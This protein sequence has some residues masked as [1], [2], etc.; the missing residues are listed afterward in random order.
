M[1]Y[2]NIPTDVRSTVDVRNAPAIQSVTLFAGSAAA[3]KAAVDAWKADIANKYKA[4][5]DIF[6][7]N[8]IYVRQR[9]Q[10]VSR[11]NLVKIIDD[12][13]GLDQLITNINAW[14]TANPTH[15]WVDIK[16]ICRAME[17]EPY[18]AIIEYMPRLQANYDNDSLSQWDVT[19]LYYDYGPVSVPDA[20]SGGELPPP[21]PCGA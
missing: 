9:S 10:E 2:N 5:I 4:I 12:G 11:I 19:I 16:Y 18:L 1:N 15:I 6:W 7:L 17:T 21:C 20:E 14:K 3:M 8:T 13:L